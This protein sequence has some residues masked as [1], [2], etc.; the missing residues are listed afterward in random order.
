MEHEKTN[1]TLVNGLYCI[2]VKGYLQGEEPLGFTKILVIVIF[3][4][5]VMLILIIETIGGIIVD[6]CLQHIAASILTAGVLD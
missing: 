5:F 4:F 3:D 6:G 2:G 1:L